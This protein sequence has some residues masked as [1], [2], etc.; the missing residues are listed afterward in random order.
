[1]NIS[2]YGTVVNSL[3]YGVPSA[4]GAMRSLTLTARFNF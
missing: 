2:N 4:A 3:T 1:V